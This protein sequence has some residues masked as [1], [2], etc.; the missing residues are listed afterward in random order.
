MSELPEIIP[1]FPLYGTILLP[2]TILPLHIFEPRYQQMIEFA[3]EQD[4]SIGMVQPINQELDQIY[5][6]G[7]LGKIEQCQQLPNENYLIRL[8]GILRFQIEKELDVTTQ[9]RK[10]V[11]NYSR[12]VNDLEE[13]DQDLDNSELL[14][15]RFRNY[16]EKKN[17]QIEWD[18]LRTI[19]IHYLVNI[20]C[21]NLDFNSIEKQA[22]LETKNLQHRWDTL[23]TLISMAIADN[24]DQLSASE[25]VN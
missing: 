3:M 17:I 24:S 11:P 18:K 15:E 20:L 2:N 12:F 7:C 9:Y 19:P 10:V 25:C 1:I 23:I 21:M 16:A 22:L 5:E 6:I 8:N 4:Q 14:Y 13:T